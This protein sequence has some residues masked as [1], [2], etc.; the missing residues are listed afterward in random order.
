M[1]L[2]IPL[3]NTILIFTG[4]SI[5]LSFNLFDAQIYKYITNKAIGF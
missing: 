5:K 2:I 1:I 3:D 4:F